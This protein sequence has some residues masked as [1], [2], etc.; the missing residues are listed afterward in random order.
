M[1]YREARVPH[2]T[3]WWADSGPEGGTI[4]PDGCMDLIVADGTVMIAGT[5]SRPYRVQGATSRSAVGLRLH[6][7]ALPT[8]LGVPAHTLTDSRVDLTA[9]DPGLA[10]AIGEA[11]DPPA[12]LLAAVSAR[13]RRSPAPQW[14]GD[15]AARLGA[16]GSVAEVAAKVGFSER[17]LRRLTLDH[18]GLTPKR[19]A[20]VARMRRALADLEGGRG[21]GQV[22]ARAG[23]SD[24]SHMGRD[25]LRLT[26]RTPA[27]FARL[28]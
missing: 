16:E 7:G 11:D 21:L 15:L 3:L 12:A 8:V 18:Y 14:A 25:F 19:F 22:A 4:L 9:I 20:A 1:T 27:S 23:Y 28:D 17:H 26:G 10:R 24:Q 5:D 13:L 6:P 2:G